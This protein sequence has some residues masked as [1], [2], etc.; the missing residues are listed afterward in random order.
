MEKNESII[1]NIFKT[2]NNKEN[3]NIFIEDKENTEN[4]FS[5]TEYDKNLKYPSTYENKKY[6]LIEPLEF[7]TN[8][9]NNNSIHNNNRLFKDIKDSKRKNILKTEKEYKTYKLNRAINTLNLK[10]HSSINN[11]SKRIKIK[12]N[13]KN[14][15]Y[16]DNENNSIISNKF[17]DKNNL[18]IKK[19]QNSIDASFINRKI[20]IYSNRNNSKLKVTRNNNTYLKKNFNSSTHHN[21][22][23]NKNSIYSSLKIESKSTTPKIS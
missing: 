7:D 5:K 1:Y 11:N 2:E 4:Y 20:C 12:R 10:L 18:S 22:K 8:K 9:E 6:I 14:L 17:N 13:N 15:I 23:Q 19:D 16:S 21:I 3:K